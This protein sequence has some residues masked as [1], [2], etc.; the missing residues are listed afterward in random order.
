MPTVP[1][2]RIYVDAREV[3]RFHRR[4]ELWATN[5][6]PFAIAAALTDT[7]KD[8]RAYV[9]GAL[10]DTFTVRNPAFK[11]AIQFEA[12]DKRAK[13][14]QAKV[15]VTEW[16]R[17]L[18]LHAIGGLKRSHSGAR[19]AV[20]T[21]AIKRTSTG[22]IPSRLKPRELRSSAKLA[23]PLLDRR[24]LIALRKKKQL[25]IY[26]TL[27]KAAKIKAR[28]PF[29]QQVEETVQARLGAHFIRRAEE[30]I[31]SAK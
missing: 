20:P 7:A 22:R 29:R 17:F 11:N 25:L 5:Q 6:L 2:A 12:A 21:R 28:W 19:V 27:V 3:V 10:V 30:A 24:G 31:A 16:G 23:G 14:I 13:P 26:Y 1:S 9:R 8:A 18:V 15:G 4:I